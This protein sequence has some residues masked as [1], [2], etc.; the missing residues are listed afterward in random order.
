M[1]SEPAGTIDRRLPLS[2][3]QPGL[4]AKDRLD[5]QAL[6]VKQQHQRVMVLISCGVYYTIRISTFLPKYCGADVRT[7]VARS[8]GRAGSR[9]SRRVIGSTCA[10]ALRVKV[11]RCHVTPRRQWKSFILINANSKCFCSCNCS[12]CAANG[13][14]VVLWG[15]AKMNVAAVPREQRIRASSNCVMHWKHY[16]WATLPNFHNAG[17][18]IH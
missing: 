12:L 13:I 8:D 1:A 5:K 14:V 16:Y 15:T 10:P 4:D 7:Y 9:P 6:T 11:H 18:K 3:P 2:V 17:A